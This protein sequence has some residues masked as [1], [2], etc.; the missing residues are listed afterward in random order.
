MN[1][2]VWK[3][4][5]LSTLFTK[6]QKCSTETL[7]SSDLSTTVILIV[8]VSSII[9]LDSDQEP[10]MQQLAYYNRLTKVFL[11]CAVT[12]VLTKQLQLFLILTGPVLQKK[13]LCRQRTWSNIPGN[14][15]G[16]KMH[17][18]LLWL[19]LTSWNMSVYLTDECNLWL[20]A[21][22]ILTMHS[23]HLQQY[24]KILKQEINNIL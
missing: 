22:W 5:I 24:K 20:L 15:M 2:F 12:R 8:P 1:Y 18:I 9:I 6:E 14:I 4:N 10:R 21:P 13:F 23:I 17:W 3:G 19:I 7:S 16:H 11:F